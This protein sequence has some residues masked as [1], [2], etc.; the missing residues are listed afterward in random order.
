M[1]DFSQILNHPDNE[2]I[3]SKLMGGTDPKVVADWLKSSYPEKDQKHLHLTIKLLKDFLGSSYADY[4]T[5]AE[6][7]LATVQSGGKLDKRLASSLLNNKT[8]QERINEV[9]D[10]KIELPDAFK[11]LETLIMARFEQVFD[12]IQEDP[13]LVNG[14]TDF[15]LLKY[16]EQYMNLLEKYDRHHNNRPDQVI[17]HNHA[18]MYVDQYT[19]LIQEAIRETLA[20]IDQEAA[21]LFQDK[22]QS[23]LEFLKPPAETNPLT[24]TK[25]LTLEAKNLQQKIIGTQTELL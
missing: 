7:H 12:K 23:K 22:I 8:Y 21:S 17:Q 19:A 16:I 2:E 4:Y 25:N 6:T 1:S 20:E 15:V 18:V 24:E 5:Q 9:L 14:K 13:A 10:N 3:I 11:R